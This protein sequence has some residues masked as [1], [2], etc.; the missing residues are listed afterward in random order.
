[1]ARRAQLRDLLSDRFLREIH[2]FLWTG[3]SVHGE[4]TDA[5]WN[6]RDHAWITAFL[7]RSLGYNPALLHGEAL[8]VSGPTGRSESVSV[9]QRPH[10][11]IVIE[12]AGA[13]DLSIKPGH[14]VSGGDFRIP[15]TGIFAN[16][17]IP[18]ARGG[19]A[20]FLDDAA[21]FERAVEEL[22][23]RR[24]RLSAVYLANEAEHLHAGH[25]SRAAGWIR[26][27]LAVHLG[28]VYGDPSD[29]YAALLSHLRA[30]LEGSAPGLS[31]LR[32][33]EAWGRIA[34]ARQGAIGRARHWIA[35]AAEPR[36]G[37]PAQ[38]A[39]QLA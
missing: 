10:S 33:E 29:L 14:R 31:G 16:A 37:L 38:I 11:W 24:N 25:L 21:E 8:F 6:C 7:A 30:F 15:I 27:P 9:H 26:S 23:R 22:P 2:Q 13:I 28:S 20:C 34:G 5:G 3:P 19:T 1:M 39:G 32:F 4:A 18:R 36:R 35:A 17:W 12:E